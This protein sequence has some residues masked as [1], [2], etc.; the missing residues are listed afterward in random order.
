MLGELLSKEVRKE[1]G[2]CLADGTMYS[3]VWDCFGAVYGLT[4]VMNQTYVADL[5]KFPNL[6]NEEPG[7]C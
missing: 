5:L 4:K 1:I 3:V 7:G 6:R 2:E